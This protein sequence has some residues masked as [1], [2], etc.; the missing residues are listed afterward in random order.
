MGKLD[1]KV[2]LVT[3]AARGIG[4]AI[5][6][7]LAREGADIVANDLNQANLDELAGEIRALGRKVLTVI[8]DVSKKNEVDRMVENTIKTFGKIDILV[9]NA[10]ITR[11][12]PFLTLSEAEWDEVIAVNLK[13]VFLTSQ[14]VAKHMVTRKYGKIISISSISSTAPE[15]NMANYGAS[16]AGINNLTKSMA[17]ALGEHKINVNAVA[18]GSIMT[19]MLHFGKTDEQYRQLMEKRIKQ[20]VLNRLGEVQDIAKVVVFLS[21]DDAAFITGQTIPVDGGRALQG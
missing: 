18:C 15:G 2:A 1:G 8:A 17:V 16:K 10:G 14:A 12:A 21:T 4:K 6:L 5:A 11:H 19:E 9:N 13:S 20:A 3:G 7:G